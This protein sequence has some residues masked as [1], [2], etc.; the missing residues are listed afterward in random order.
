MASVITNSPHKV[1]WLRYCHATGATDRKPLL[2]FVTGCFDLGIW[3]NLVC[4]PLRSSQN[5]GSGTVVHSLGGL[6]SFPGTM[7][8]SPS[9]GADGAGITTNGTNNSVGITSLPDVRVGSLV[10][11]CHSLRTTGGQSW[12]AELTDASRS[13]YYSILSGGPSGAS[14]QYTTASQAW[15]PLDIGGDI[16][17]TN[18]IMAI[19][20]MSGSAMNSALNNGSFI[21]GSFGTAPNPINIFNVGR[22]QDN[23]VWFPGVHNFSA[24]FDVALS[25]SQWGDFRALYKSTLG[26]GL[27]L[28]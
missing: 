22:R 3:E 7:V 20:S 15:G 1:A 26:V 24:V 9:W 23:N 19:I 4:W 27:S 18:P 21:A 13:S 5:A 12:V 17:T 16:R 25:F 28:P 10:H 11:C 14:T 2:D 8:N 6:G